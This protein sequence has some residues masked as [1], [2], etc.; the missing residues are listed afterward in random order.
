MITKI[1]LANV[2]SKNIRTSKNRATNTI[3][4]P[5]KQGHQT[6]FV[7]IYPTY[8]NHKISKNISFSG[9][10]NPLVNYLST[11]SAILRH[12]HQALN[13]LDEAQMSVSKYISNAVSE[14]FRADRSFINRSINC[15]NDSIEHIRKGY[16]ISKF[17][18]DEK[19]GYSGITSVNASTILE[20]FNKNNLRPIEKS[21][22][23]FY[24]DILKPVIKVA[25]GEQKFSI[26]FADKRLGD[27]NLV[28]FWL[29][30]LG[31]SKVPEKEND[32]IDLLNSKL[33]ELN[34]SGDDSKIKLE[35][36]FRDTIN[37]YFLTEVKKQSS[38]VQKIIEHEQ[39]KLEILEELKGKINELV[40]SVNEPKTKN[41]SFFKNSKDLQTEKFIKFIKNERDLK[42]NVN[43]T[44]VEDI[45]LSILEK[46]GI[47]VKDLSTNT[48]KEYLM[49]IANDNN[50]RRES[51]EN[52]S[53][54]IRKN[55]MLEKAMAEKSKLA[56]STFKEGALG[57]FD[58]ELL[59]KMFAQNS[60]DATKILDDMKTFEKEANNT[61]M[62]M[63]P[64]EPFKN[65]N[66]T[67]VD[68]KEN[69]NIILSLVNERIATAK[70]EEEV[71]KIYNELD[72][73]ADALFDKDY[74]DADNKWKSIVKTALS[75]WKE[76]HLP[77][78]IQKQQQS[79]INIQN[80]LKSDLAKE[81][82][83]TGIINTFF[84]SETITIEEKAFLAKKLES[85]SI[86]KSGQ[87]LC[88]FLVKDL[89]NNKARQR[90]INNLIEDEKIADETF[91]YLKDE[92][93]NV[94]RKQDIESPLINKN[95]QK[96][97]I[98]DLF[99]RQT[100]HADSLYSMSTKEK[101]SILNQYPDGE[102][103]ILAKEVKGKYLTEK[104]IEAF[105]EESAK[106]D[107]ATR[108]DDVMKN[109]QVEVDGKKYNLFE[110]MTDENNQLAKL[111]NQSS[112]INQEQM[113][114]VI[115]LLSQNNAQG[116]E[117]R[118]T[119]DVMLDKIQASYPQYAQQCRQ[120]RTFLQKLKDGLINPSSAYAAIG[121]IG[122]IKAGVAAGAT[123]GATIGTAGGP[124][125]TA[126]GAAIG[127]TAGGLIGPLLIIG[128]N[129]QKSFS[130]A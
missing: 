84:K 31:I 30:K 16:E 43:G 120:A 59:K 62:K 46:D 105:E 2:N 108:L 3:D 130:R 57:N 67:D 22:N 87:D 13:V 72:S 78:I 55:W 128:T 111:I 112:E 33:R 6:E 1:Q 73:F 40:N 42:A 48:K 88:K 66:S 125:G 24:N 19:T 68:L 37:K 109:L 54:I 34:K 4:D 116:K 52:A 70:D 63:I 18:K 126:A 11:K 60:N 17:V 65:P 56:E 92:F 5:I 77:T 12:D 104:S 115:S 50:L 97:S 79:Y 129:L 118:A 82:E 14:V 113:K 100:P 47:Y 107:L 119:L 122:S 114:Q 28:E 95:I 38:P 124:A 81:I 49:E 103:N 25:K 93:I 39:P 9:N 23:E 45:L 58:S 86:K 76:K 94:V 69:S 7:N 83:D 91:G 80:F 110:I 74:A 20:Y 36:L 89:P 75:Q 117:M 90:V 44:T 61:F 98:L 8:L 53:T 41:F 121:I 51:I 26:L 10:Y 106:Y 64:Q 71:N 102:L 27:E 96:E 101:L 35:H 99:L 85:E 123:A 15:D 127:A 21:Y 32:K 29:K